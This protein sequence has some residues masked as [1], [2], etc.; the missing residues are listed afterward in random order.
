[1]VSPLESMCCSMIRVKRRRRKTP[2]WIRNSNLKYLS[3]KTHEKFSVLN[4]TLP[5]IASLENLHKWSEFICCRD[6]HFICSWI[7]KVERVWEQWPWETPWLCSQSIIK[8]STDLLL[9][10]WEPETIL[11]AHPFL[12]WKVRYKLL[13]KC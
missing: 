13:V 2:A 12:L 1:M 11:K 5:L 10:L 4:Y 7:E 3:R 6:M 9:R 8:L